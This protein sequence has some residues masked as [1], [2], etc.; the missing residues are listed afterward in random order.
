MAVPDGFPT[1]LPPSRF[2]RAGNAVIA[3]GGYAVMGLA[4]P[5][6]VGETEYGL[7]SVTYCISGASASDYVSVGSVS[8]GT[9][10]GQPVAWDWAMHT[11]DGCYTIPV[12]TAGGS[13]SIGVRREGS[14]LRIGD[15]EA[16]WLPVDQ[17][18]SD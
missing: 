7:E 12:A 18:T 2:K 1:V 11:V 6:L 13:F 5:A 15:V 14:N 8:T 9:A 17:L 3:G 10:E 16:S 4:G